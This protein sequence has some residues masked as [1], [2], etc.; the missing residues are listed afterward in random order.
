M[1]EID[2]RDVA[3]WAHHRN[4]GVVWKALNETSRQWWRNQYNQW[5]KIQAEIQRRKDLESRG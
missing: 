2:D 3:A 5:Q 4:R 1:E